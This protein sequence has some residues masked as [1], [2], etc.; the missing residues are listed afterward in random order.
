MKVLVSKSFVYLHIY[1]IYLVLFFVP[2]CLFCALFIVV[3]Q[4]VSKS[5]FGTRKKNSDPFFEKTVFEDKEV[6]Y[7]NFYLF[8]H[9]FFIYTIIV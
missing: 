7:F 8:S 1:N 5:F 3:L 4:H 6:F 2:C 9:V